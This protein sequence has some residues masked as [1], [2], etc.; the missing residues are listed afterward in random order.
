[1]V[2]THAKPIGAEAQFATRIDTIRARVA[3]KLVD[4]IQQTDAALPQMTGDGSDAVEAVATAYRWFHDISGI[5]PTLGFE[6]TG[7]QA[8]ACADLLVD[9]FRARRGLS[10]DELISLADGLESLRIVALNETHSA[11]PRQRST[12]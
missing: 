5:G 10:A 8:R 2:E 1:M 11:E 3:L 9:P 6:G 7:K 12:P 4:R